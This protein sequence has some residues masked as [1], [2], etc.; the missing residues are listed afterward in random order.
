MG[1]KQTDETKQK[2]STA[3]KGKLIGYAAQ[4][5]GQKII[6]DVIRICPRCNKEFEIRRWKKTIFC[7]K[8]CG[9]AGNGGLRPNAGKRGS[10]YFCFESNKQVYLDSTWEREYAEYLDKNNIRWIR[11][12]YLDWID[13][14][15][16]SHKY[17]ADFY[18][19]NED[20]YIDIKNDYLITLDKEKISRVIERHDVNLE[21]I[22]RDKLNEILQA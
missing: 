9:D 19:I 15:G 12:T 11:P 17:Y 14:N 7:S 6:P 5:K 22:S 2:I 10:W 20:K 3:L 13:V 21:I 18:L 1:R 16:K 4:T 8:K